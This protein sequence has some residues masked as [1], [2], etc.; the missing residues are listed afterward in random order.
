MINRNIFC[1]S[2]RRIVQTAVLPGPGKGV[3][4]VRVDECAIK[5]D[6]REYKIAQITT[7]CLE[8]FKTLLDFLSEKQGLT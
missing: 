2:G 4:C 8:N 1:K 3:S 6:D 7:S 5:M